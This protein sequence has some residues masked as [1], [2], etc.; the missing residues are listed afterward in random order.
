TRGDQGEIS[1]PALAT[2]ETLG[3]VRERELRDACELLGIEPP[4]LF[5][6]GDGTLAE[7]DSDELRDAVVAAIRRV[8]PAIVI[9][10]DANGGYGHADHIAIHHATLAA[11]ELAANDDHRPELGAAHA[12]AKL[13]AT[14]YP[15]S[16]LELMNEGLRQLGLPEISFGD[17]QTIASEDFG[18]PD[19]RV[20]TVVAVDRHYERRMAS[21][22]AHRTQ[23]GPE[24]IF[25][26]FS[27]DLNRRLATFDYFVRLIPAPPAGAW[28][29][30]E[31]SLWAGI[32]L[33]G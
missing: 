27:D 18:T 15:R 31:A 2:R 12:A 17:V 13:Y 29:P 8:R 11:F 7:I 4:T 10:F 5:D 26:R 6:Y 3:E 28:L 25:A 1:D 22:F 23:Y 32:E 33:E 19:E 16:D 14:A 20:T 21:L 24:S 9:T 30:D